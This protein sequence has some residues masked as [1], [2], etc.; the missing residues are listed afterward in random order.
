MLLEREIILPNEL[1]E[2]LS[3]EIIGHD[4]WRQKSPQPKHES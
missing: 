1:Y 4:K 2:S 3:D